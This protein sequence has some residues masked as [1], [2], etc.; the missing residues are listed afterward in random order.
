MSRQDTKFGKNNQTRPS[1]EQ[2]REQL[3]DQLAVN[4]ACLAELRAA[5]ELIADGMPL[6][7]ALADASPDTTDLVSHYWS[8]E[9]MCRMAW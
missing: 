9:E 5:S 8:F 2:A 1:L 4:L 6:G 3:G 7:Q